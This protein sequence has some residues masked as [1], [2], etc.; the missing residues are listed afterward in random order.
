[1]YMLLLPFVQSD[2]KYYF[3]SLSYSHRVNLGR[4]VAKNSLT[5]M[6][7]KARKFRCYSLLNGAIFQWLPW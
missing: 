3:L 1:M 5:G 4:V 7:T 6:S 2:S